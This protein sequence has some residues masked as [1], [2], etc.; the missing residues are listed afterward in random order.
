MSWMAVALQHSG[1]IAL[2]REAGSSMCM[3][4]VM[5]LVQDFPGGCWYFGAE[6]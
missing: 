6:T 1:I 3:G 4:P 2:E 5:A